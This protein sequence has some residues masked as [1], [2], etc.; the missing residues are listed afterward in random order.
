LSSVFSFSVP[1]PFSV[2][3]IQGVVFVFCRA[4]LYQEHLPFSCAELSPPLDFCKLTGP[5][6]GI[7]RF[8]WGP[9]WRT[10]PAYKEVFFPKGGGEAF[11]LHRSLLRVTLRK[12]AQSTFGLTLPKLGLLSRISGSLSLFPGFVGLPPF[13]PLSLFPAFKTFGFTGTR[14]GSPFPFS[15][16]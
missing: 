3:K 5:R 10:L 11:F 2:E 12:S 7:N 9:R 6:S 16:F 8:G 4:S 13:Q 14:T 1:C 15:I